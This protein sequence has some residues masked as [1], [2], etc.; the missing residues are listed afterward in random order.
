M[1]YLVVAQDQGTILRSLNTFAAWNLVGRAHIYVALP[2]KRCNPYTASFASP[3]AAASSSSAGSVTALFSSTAAACGS[4]QRTRRRSLI[5]P[6]L[7]LSGRSLASRGRLPHVAT[8]RLSP[9]SLP[10][11]LH[12]VMLHVA[13]KALAN[14]ARVV[15]AVK[16]A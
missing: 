5:G 7:D 10:H 15:R 2:T 11:M 1:S 9:G 3:S 4:A 16:M 13:R 12:L 14:A 6:G 8:A